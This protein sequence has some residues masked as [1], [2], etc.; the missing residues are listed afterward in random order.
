[1]AAA[2]PLAAPFGE[3]PDG[4][5]V[6]R[7]ALSGGGLSLGLLTYG[8]TVQ[9][10]RLEGVAHPLV[11][12]APRLAPYLGPMRHFGALVGRFANRIGGGG[13]EID[14][15]RHAVD[16]N[17]AGRHTLHGGR[18][19]ASGM[20]WE[21]EAAA[22]DRA[23]LSLRMPDGHMGFPG[24]LKVRADFSLP[25]AGVLR[26]EMRAQTD[27]PTPCS[28]AHHGYFNLDGGGD[29]RDH[30]LRLSAPSVLE[31]DADLIPTGR[32]TPCAGGRL[33]FSAARALAEAEGLDHCFALPVAEGP[34]PPFAAALTGRGGVR[35]H[36]HT[37]APGLQVYDGAG[38]AAAEGLEGR[39]HGPHA[40]VA[41]ESQGFPDA[42]NRPD[43][44]NAILRPGET[45]R[46]VVEYRFAAP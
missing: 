25:G 15:A 33:D 5:L 37:D 30:R 44:P 2:P 17:Q 28:F 1:M 26:I 20:V 40:G 35:L 14:G 7:L 12:G 34:E 10:L 39:R 41:L 45:Y 18:E 9:D 19:G 13:F 38:I 42:P 16:R 29:V 11:L 31:V 21:I 24:D 43:F 3:M 4:R 27:R 8:A 36:V 32:L 22:P 6:Q 23:A 46:H